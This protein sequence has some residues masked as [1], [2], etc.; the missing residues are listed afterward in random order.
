MKVRHFAAH[1]WTAVVQRLFPSVK[2]DIGPATDDG[3]YYDFDLDYQFITDDLPKIEAEMQRL[4]NQN[5][6]FESQI[7]SRSEAHRLFFNRQNLQIIPS[8]RHP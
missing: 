7:I 8:Q 1:I 3:F 6:I 5:Q 4:I 2:F